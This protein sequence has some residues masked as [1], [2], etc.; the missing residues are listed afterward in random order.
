MCIHNVRTSHRS[1]SMPSHV[2][3]KG[4]ARRGFTLIELLVVIAIIA[5]LVGLLLPA[6]QKVRSAAYRISCS[7]NLHNIGLAVH[8]YSSAIDSLPSAGYG[9][10][11]A[12]G[13]WFPP[14]NELATGVYPPSYQPGV[15]AQLPG[16]TLIPDGNKRQTAGWA[17]QLLPYVEQEPLWK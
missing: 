6:V 10:G 14:A 16:G 2:L 5:I 13:S 7:N 8:N 4:R 9:T 12:G 17:F 11:I 1:S 15:G 3:A